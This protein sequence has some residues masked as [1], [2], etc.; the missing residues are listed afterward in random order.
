MNEF[1]ISHRARHTTIQHHNTGGLFLV[2]M[3]THI[4]HMSN[5]N[6]RQTK[7]FMLLELPTSIEESA[8]FMLLLFETPHR[9]P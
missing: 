9:H 7:E 1:L 8:T 4:R 3:A 2:T 6:N 5:C